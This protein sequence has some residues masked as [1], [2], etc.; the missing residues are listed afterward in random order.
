MRIMIKGMKMPM[1]CDDCP[2]FDDNGDYPTC[3]LTGLSK[4]Y[5]FPIFD[6]RMDIC[7]L[8]ETEETVK[9]KDCRWGREVCG[10]IECFVDSNAPTEYHGYEWFCPNGER[11]EVNEHEP[12]D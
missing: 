1:C 12:D 11:R 6:K 4:G 3:I 2:V 10:N 7:P 5:N 8:I 9:C